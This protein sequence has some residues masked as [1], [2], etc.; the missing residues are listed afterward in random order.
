M[1][2]ISQKTGKRKLDNGMT[3]EV[4]KIFKSLSVM[5]DINCLTIEDQS[6]LKSQGYLLVY[7]ALTD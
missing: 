2:S 7:C 3:M 6:G 1:D 5:Y 4:S